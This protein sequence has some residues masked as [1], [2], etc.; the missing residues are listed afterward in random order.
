MRS[1]LAVVL[2]VL[3][4]IVLVGALVHRSGGRKATSPT[5]T[6]KAKPKPDPN[7]VVTLHGPLPGGLLIADRG[8]NRILLVDPARRTL[9]NFPTARDRAQGRKLVFDDDTF[10]EPGGKSLVTNEE[11]HHDIL[12]ID[13]GVILAT[14]GGTMVSRADLAGWPLVGA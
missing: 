8:N 10:V 5:T 9:W 1:R 6:R 4:A 13:I 7:R 12:S 3:V 11:E 14:F 2:V